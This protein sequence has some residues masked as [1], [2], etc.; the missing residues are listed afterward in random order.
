MTFLFLLLWL[1]QSYTIPLAAA[2]AKPALVQKT[3]QV[4]AAIYTINITDNGFSPATLTIKTGESVRWQNTTGQPQTVRSGPPPRILLP[5]ILLNSAEEVAGASVRRSAFV[6]TNQFEGNVQPGQNFEQSFN[7]PGEF[8]YHLVG[9]LHS[10]RIV[11]E[12]SQTPP[13]P[14]TDTSTAPLPMSDAA[15]FLYTG[16]NAPQK[17]VAE[18]AINPRRVMVLRGLVFDRAG[19]PLSGVRVTILNAPEFGHTFSGDD[20]TFNLALNGGGTFT[21]NLEKSGYL[22]V[23]RTVVDPPWQEYILLDGVVMTQLDEQ[24][25]TINLNSSAPIQIAQGTVQS[26]GDGERQ[27][28]L[29]VTRGIT[30]EMVLPNGTTQSLTSLNVRATEYTVGDLGAMSMPGSLPSNSGYTYAVEFSVDEALQ[31]NASEVRFSKPLINYTQN[32]I[33]AP[34]GSGVPTGFYDRETGRWVPS[35][36]GRVIKI[37]GITDGKADVDVTGDGV[38]DTGEPLAAL[39]ISDDERASLATLYSGGQELWRVEIPH[40]TPWDHNWPFGPPPDAEA[41]KLKEFVWKDPNDPCRTAGSIIGCE[42]Q[43]VGEVVPLIGAPFSLVYQSER[44]PGW[45]VAETLEIPITGPALPPDIRGVHM[46]IDIGGRRFEQK[47]CVVAL[48][49]ANT[50]KDLPDVTPNI[51]YPF[52]WDGLDAFG[53]PM[54][55]RPVARITVTYIYTLKYYPAA[56]EFESSFGQF[57]SETVYWNG[58]GSCGNQLVSGWNR[59]T[60]F[61]W[62]YKAHFFCGIGIGQT[63]YR[64]I[65]SWDAR[66]TA[67]LGGWTLDAH[68]AYDPQERVLYR[69]DG[70][71]EMADALGTMV[72]TVAGGPGS[73][74]FPEA[75][76]RPAVEADVDYLGDIALTPDGSIFAYTSLNRNHIIKVD[77]EGIIHT[78]A[79]KDRT[80]GEPTG[81]GGPALEATLGNEIN[82]LATGP[83]GSVYFT[84]TGAHYPAGY[85]RKI[86]PNGI[87]STIAGVNYNHTANTSGDG[88]PA[89][90]ARLTAPIDLVLGPDGSIYFSERAG[91]ANGWKARVRKIDPNGIVTTV[92]GGGDKAMTDPALANG[93]LPA[94][95]VNIGRVYG[96][97]FGPDGAMYLALPVEKVVLRLGTDGLLSHFAGNGQ[98]D[99]GVPNGPATG[100]GIGQPLKVA[101]D[102]AGTVYVFSASSRSDRLRIWRVDGNGD[103]EVIAGRA[104]G[105]GYSLGLS[106]ESALGTCIGGH[107]RGLE[108][109]PDGILYYGDG[110]YQIRKLVAPLPG[111]G[112]GEFA[113]PSADGS[114]LYEFDR[115]A[116]ICAQR[117]Q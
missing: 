90:Q 93:G 96:I 36:N 59:D 22:P 78:Y 7:T 117:T 98:D 101:V 40:F 17:N 111:F 1:I 53:R 45:K 5:L 16:E 66:A 38:A 106:G 41:P 72:V 82:G 10:G 57:P 26:D 21:V 97:T 91:G 51:T 110:R 68:H 71:R 76:G 94:T 87:I 52:V 64:A 80:R 79:G 88:G 14:P 29:L 77:P 23:Q 102:R 100:M 63:I 50:C 83:D 47:W 70:T 13:P 112:V 85:I 27:A 49:G 81:D 65:G 73:V 109:G 61:E 12:Q 30:A 116:A 2:P 86:D 31:V 4:A 11:V 20:G 33:G 28:T 18:N 114:E 69:G 35:K 99:T 56:A 46:T 58:R 6:P 105:C 44:T 43:T 34:V 95:S 32:F 60:D 39:G 113:L 84:L 55:G 104:S 3:W 115:L 108:I 54:A 74:A 48:A 19:H 107:S 37:V 42:T 62:I 92:V 103:M 67:G 24:V 25:T 9:S 8:A 89:S 15:N 75:E